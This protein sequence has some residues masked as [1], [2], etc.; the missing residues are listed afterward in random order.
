MRQCI[1]CI[2]G[3]YDGIIYRWNLKTNTVA[4]SQKIKISAEERIQLAN[5]KILKT[6]VLPYLGTEEAVGVAA[7]QADRMN[8]QLQA[9]AALIFLA[10]DNI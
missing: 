8:R 2:E 4:L 6:T 10:G 3:R 1:H 9:D 5:C 7:G